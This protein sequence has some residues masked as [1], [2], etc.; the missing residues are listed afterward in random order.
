MADL[1]IGTTV[2]GSSIWTQSNFPLFPTGNSLL[3]RDFTIYSTN[4]KPQAADNDFVSKAN[5]GIY[6][7]ALTLKNSNSTSQMLNIQGSAAGL[8]LSIANSDGTL[9][10]N[11]YQMYAQGDLLRFR[12]PNGV[13]AGLIDIFQWNN[14]TGAKQFEVRGNIKVLTGGRILDSAGGVVYSPQNKPTAADV[15]AL[16]LTGGTVT[17]EIITTSSGGNNFRISGT[18]SVFQRF[19][20][21]GWYFLISDSATGTY[22]SFR[23]LTIGIADGKV[24]MDQGLIVNGPT[25]LNGTTNTQTLNANALSVNTTISGGNTVTLS[26]ASDPV[27]PSTGS[28]LNTPEF[29]AGW[30]SRGS[31]SNNSKGYV[32]FYGQ[33]EVG[34]AWR[35]CLSVIGYASSNPTWKFN[36]SGEFWSPGSITSNT[37][38]SY[39]LVN[40]GTSVFQR[41]DGGNWYLM[42]SDSINGSWNSLRPLYINKSSGNVTMGHQ[43]NVGGNIVGGNELQGANGNV[44]IATDGNVWGSRFGGWIAD[45][46]N[47]NYY[48]RGS[49]DGAY[50][51][52]NDAWNKANDAQVNR[53]QWIRTAGQ[54]YSDYMGNQYRNIIVPA[55]YVM[56]GL[57]ANGSTLDAGRIVFGRMQVYKDNGGWIDSNY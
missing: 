40:S 53:A 36:Q 44:R 35:A 47:N 9:T 17:G 22:N 1:K 41:F 11:N 45:W 26:Y 14:A 15:G 5:G 52:A 28:F 10:N 39:R 13:D 56:I 16:A 48:P 50:A 51:R 32:A 30:K 34:T 25:N 42:L 31:D 43:L 7:G 49:G 55:G 54:Y 27:N 24:S 21:N 3:Y 37:T 46:V 12:G 6:L 29:R 38:D 18:K 19:D 23:P 4:D 20:G 57:N 8:M 2:G 33:E